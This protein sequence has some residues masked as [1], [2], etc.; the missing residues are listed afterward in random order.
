M[1]LLLLALETGKMSENDVM[2]LIQTGLERKLFNKQDMFIHALPFPT[3]LLFK[4]VSG[5]EKKNIFVVWM[6][7]NR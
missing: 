1:K 4:N 7:G 5:D 6:R 2:S 3:R